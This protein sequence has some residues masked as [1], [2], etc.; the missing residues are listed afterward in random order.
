MMSQ[1]KKHYLLHVVAKLVE[2]SDFQ[3]LPKSHIYPYVPVHFSRSCHIW[4]HLSNLKRAG[5]IGCARNCF[6]FFI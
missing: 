6:A 1:N 5:L 3:H 4:T 2:A